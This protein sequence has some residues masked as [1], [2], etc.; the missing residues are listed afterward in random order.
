MQEVKDENASLAKAST[1]ASN[2][3][4]SPESYLDVLAEEKDLSGLAHF[5]QLVNAKYN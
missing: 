4:V 2:A 1:E 5:C 3:E